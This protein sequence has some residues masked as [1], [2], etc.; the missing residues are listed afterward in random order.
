MGRRRSRH[1]VWG[2]VAGTTVALGL[3]SAVSLWGLWGPVT[4]WVGVFV[5]AFIVAGLVGGSARTSARIGTKYALGAVACGGLVAAFGG[6]GALL[7]VMVAVTSPVV[8]IMLRT[9]RLNA[10]MR[11]AGARDASE[12]SDG[13]AALDG[14]PSG[15]AGP[16]G[17]LVLLADM[18]GDDGV[19]GLDDPAL[20]DVWRRSYVRLEASRAADARLEV[21]R[22]RQLY[23]DELV[24]RHPAE[25][26][27]WLASGARAAGNPLPFLTRPT[28]RGDTSEDG[29]PQ[30]HGSEAS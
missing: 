25:V 27:Q 11:Q 28:W 20:C 8:R 23:L 3:A 10:V 26:R 19:L 4:S 17:R 9:G 7:V 15:A 29:R 5:T 12:R 22:L 16:V 30:A 18:P 14:S 1:G 2:L 21:V 24:R 6:S 13:P